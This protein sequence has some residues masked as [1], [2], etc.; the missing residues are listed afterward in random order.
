MAL[1]SLTHCLL[2]NHQHPTLLPVCVHHLVQGRVSAVLLQASCLC[3]SHLHLRLLIAIKTTLVAG[4]RVELV[5][6]SSCTSGR[7]KLVLPSLPSHAHVASPSLQGG[8]F[9]EEQ[10]L[11]ITLPLARN[12][13]KKPYVIYFG[14][15]RKITYTY[16]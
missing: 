16:V 5:F 13:N 3:L 9:P 10:S 6:F 15:K 7:G 1:L 12:K 11:T 8:F 14:E 2:S 4:S